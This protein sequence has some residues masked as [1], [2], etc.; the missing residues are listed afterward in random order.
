MRVMAAAG[1]RMTVSN[2]LCLMRFRGTSVGLLK[3]VKIL[4]VTSAEKT[5][6]ACTPGDSDG[7]RGQDWQDCP[8]E[9]PS[10]AR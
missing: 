6:F 4:G 8:A 7:S 2:C 5:I 1:E 10:P 9:A 3:A